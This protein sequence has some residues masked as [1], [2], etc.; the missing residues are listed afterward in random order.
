MALKGLNNQYIAAE[1]HNGALLEQRKEPITN[2]EAAKMTSPELQG[3]AMRGW[4][5]D[6]SSVPCVSFKAGLRAGRQ[7]GF[8]K[9]DI[10]SLDEFQPHEMSRANLSWHLSDGLDGYVHVPE[11]PFRSA[12]CR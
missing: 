7:A 5:V 2:D 10:A 1:G 4:V 12:A 3:T 8:R 9:A 11:L 6:W